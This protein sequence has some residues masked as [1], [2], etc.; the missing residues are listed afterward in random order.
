MRMITIYVIILGFLWFL[1]AHVSYAREV[2]NH[3]VVVDSMWERASEDVDDN[4]NA[5]VYSSQYLE[6]I[7]ALVS[8][9]DVEVSDKESA[10]SIMATWMEKL[11]T[12]SSPE[13]WVWRDTGA[14]LT[15]RS[16]SLAEVDGVSTIYNYVLLWDGEKVRSIV[17]VSKGTEL[18][19]LCE[20]CENFVLSW[21]YPGVELDINRA[22]KSALL[23]QSIAPTSSDEAL[24]NFYTSFAREQFDNY[25]EVLGTDPI[26]NGWR[27]L[28]DESIIVP[29][30][31]MGRAQLIA[32]YHPWSDTALVTVWE[33]NIVLDVAQISEVYLFDGAFMYLNE[34]LQVDNIIPPWRIESFPPVAVCTNTTSA[35]MTMQYT[36]FRTIALVNEN[37]TLNKEQMG[38]A[39]MKFLS[40]IL[41]VGEY[42]S[43]KVVA[44]SVSSLLIRCLEKD[45]ELLG[46]NN[47]ELEKTLKLMMDF[48]S[49]Y[50]QSLRPK[51]YIET[52]NGG[53]IVILSGEN[54]AQFIVMIFSPSDKSKLNMVY[55]LNFDDAIRKVIE[56]SEYE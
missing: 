44:N 24:E 42:Y 55:L 8:W 11:N 35:V 18:G 15:L 25:N 28:L 14:T 7:L 5:C 30:G 26:I 4:Y 34:I 10:R 43:D 40:Y 19:H 46:S 37:P 17:F 36:I 33:N 50:I 32:F 1:V 2:N 38:F 48:K 49:G 23:F 12:K 53:R 6:E 3:G 56:E 27:R 41:N 9:D 31:E 39:G 13:K 47:P 54:K 51:G 22:I 52:N 45:K 29:I 16:N 20:V 21:L